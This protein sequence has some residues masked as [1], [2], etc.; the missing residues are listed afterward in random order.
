MGRKKK[1]TTIPGACDTIVTGIVDGINSWFD[2]INKTWS[3]TKKKKR[4]TK[5][6]KI[7]MSL[8]DFKNK[9][10]QTIKKAIKQLEWARYRVQKPA[11]FGSKN[12]NK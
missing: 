11:R 2:D 3:G 9:E 4:K 8:S 12:D 10:R 6:K 1:T 7:D 5:A